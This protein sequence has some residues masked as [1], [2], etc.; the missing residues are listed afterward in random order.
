MSLKHI[1]KSKKK[2]SIKKKNIYGGADDAAGGMTAADLSV[3]M[4]EVVN[5]SGDGG[6]GGGGGGAAASSARLE[7]TPAHLRQVA[8]CVM[9]LKNIDKFDLRDLIAQQTKII[10]DM[11]LSLLEIQKDFPGKRVVWKQEFK[12]NLNKFKAGLDAFVSNKDM[13]IGAITARYNGTIPPELVSLNDF[14]QGFHQ[15]CENFLD[16]G[17]SISPE[18]VKTKLIGKGRFT[19][20]DVPEISKSTLDDNVFKKMNFVPSGRGNEAARAEERSGQQRS[21]EEEGEEGGGEEG[22]GEEGGGEEGEGEEGGGE[23]PRPSATGL[24]GTSRKKQS[25]IKYV[26]WLALALQYVHNN[27]VHPDRLTYITNIAA[28]QGLFYFDGCVYETVIGRFT[29]DTP[30]EE[31]MRTDMMNTINHFMTISGKPTLSVSSFCDYKQVGSPVYCITSPN[32]LRDFIHD[33]CPEFGF[34]DSVFNDDPGKQNRPFITVSKVFLR[35]K[36]SLRVKPESLRL[37]VSIQMFVTL[38]GGPVVSDFFTEVSIIDETI[39]VQICEFCDKF[40]LGSIAWIKSI[41]HGPP[42]DFGI[43]IISLLREWFGKYG[44]MTCYELNIYLNTLNDKGQNPNNFTKTQSYTQNSVTALQSA[45]QEFNYYTLNVQ[46]TILDLLMKCF[47]GITFDQL[48]NILQLLISRLLYYTTRD[49]YITQTQDVRIARSPL[50]QL[51]LDIPSGLSQEPFARLMGTV[52]SK[53]A[54]HD[55][56]KL[57]NALIR[58]C[59]DRNVD[60]SFFTDLGTPQH[61]LFND[62]FQERKIIFFPFELIRFIRNT[63]QDMYRYLDFEQIGFEMVKTALNAYNI[64]LHKTTSALFFACLKICR[65]TKL[66]DFPQNQVEFM[67]VPYDENNVSFKYVC[68]LSVKRQPYDAELWPNERFFK[69]ASASALSF[70]EANKEQPEV[71]IA[72]YLCWMAKNG[73]NDLNTICRSLVRADRATGNDDMVSY[74]DVRRFAPELLSSI[75]QFKSEL[76]KDGY[77]GLKLSMRTDIFLELIE[78]MDHTVTENQYGHQPEITNF[79][80]RQP[81]L[82]NLRQPQ[83]QAQQQGKQRPLFNFL[84][85]TGEGWRRPVAGEGW[86]RPVAAEARQLEE[87]RQQFEEVRRPEMEEAEVRR[88]EMEET[89]VQRQQ[90]ENPNQQKAVKK[91]EKKAKKKAAKQAARQAA[92]ARAEAESQAEAARQ[93]EARAEAKRQAAEARAEA[94][95]RAEE[96]AAIEAAEYSNS[97]SESQSESEPYSKRQRIQAGGTYKLMKNNQ[98]KLKTRKFKTRKFKTRKFKTR[99]FKTRKLKTPK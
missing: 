6:G 29:G 64:I 20:E 56:N 57:N 71:P 79:F 66:I 83:Q 42:G 94:A 65:D 53:R 93:A 52:R 13:F 36:E 92:E 39:Y 49:A 96:Q 18:D 91:A 7:V 88:P 28:A 55:I 60:N 16:V 33:R 45:Y 1:H 61:P 22:G 8:I 62:M 85:E 19:L 99:K 75:E 11:K 63:F 26:S 47:V 25:I 10:E 15:M 48:Q 2:K 86:R 87:L 5:T 97:Q 21:S 51:V 77:T 68:S 74:A 31:T 72:P 40:K 4:A 37:D 14:F 73:P 76:N 38:F 24:L 3:F 90:E 44:S 35:Y 43:F 82:V 69:Y 9:S 98:I 59:Q 32:E 78:I 67:Q 27:T 58:L 80:K 81:P 34:T 23:E 12:D 46:K 17:D 89:E 41:N 50:Q 70:K 84:S 95:R 54:N 30:A